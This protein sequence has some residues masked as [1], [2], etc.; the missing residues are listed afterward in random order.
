MNTSDENGPFLL[1]LRESMA[2]QKSATIARMKELGCEQAQLSQFLARIARLERLVNVFAA[3]CEIL[4][5]GDYDT[6]LPIM[7][8]LNP[9]LLNPHRKIQQQ[10]TSFGK[11]VGALVIGGLLI[12]IPAYLFGLLKR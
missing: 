12:V 9:A 1:I 11:T 4:K 3:S 10:E 2:K 7:E 5:S 8:G 6:S